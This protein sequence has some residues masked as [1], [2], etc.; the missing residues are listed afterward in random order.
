MVNVPMRYQTIDSVVKLLRLMQLGWA[1]KE[2]DF[3]SRGGPNLVRKVIYLGFCWH[4][5]LLERKR[6][7]MTALPL[8]EIK[9]F[10]AL[11]FLTI[12]SCDSRSIV[13]GP[14]LSIRNMKWYRFRPE[15]SELPPADLRRRRENV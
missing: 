5:V 2:Y 1:F 13:P 15:Y 9:P 7:A 14:V 8:E 12:T 4:Q 10:D 6:M 3:W 11:F